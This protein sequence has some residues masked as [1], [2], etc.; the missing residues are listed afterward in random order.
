MKVSAVTA[1]AAALV[2][3][4][5]VAGLLG[6]WPA[7]AACVLLIVA[8]CIFVASGNAGETP[9]PRRRS[10]RLRVWLSS[11]SYIEGDNL[12]MRI[13][14]E[15][16]VKVTVAPKTAGGHDAPIDGAV[17]FTVDDPSV[18]TVQPID[19]TS[20]Y[21]VGVAPGAALVS[22]SFDADLGEGVRTITATGAL[23]V[24]AAEAETA[25]IVFGAAEQQ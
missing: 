22:A 16:K 20:A 25:E 14:N 11:A 17:T 15:Q 2:I 12:V 10:A 1:R 8:F 7:V 24:A 23:E 19:D 9:P 6:G 4:L 3:V 18:A 21:I 5:V 13:T